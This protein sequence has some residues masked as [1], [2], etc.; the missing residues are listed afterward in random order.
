M[1]LENLSA[2]NE[3]MTQTLAGGIGGGFVGGVIATLGFTLALLI[4]LA[5]YI[6]FAFAWMTIAKK[7]KHKYAWLAWIP[8]ANIA[9]VLQLGGFH[10]A[11]VFL[12]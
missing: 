10:W 7:L 11:W 9:L 12:I 1:A 2:L 5:G 8:I 3:T 4:S 6:Y